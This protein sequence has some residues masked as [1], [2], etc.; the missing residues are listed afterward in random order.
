MKM[1]KQICVELSMASKLQEFLDSEKIDIKIA[2]DPPGDIEIVKVD[3]RRESGSS[4]IYSGGWISCEM[5]RNLAQKM[6][7]S[8]GQM[9]KLLNYLD[10]KIRHCSLGCFK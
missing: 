8:I 6:E 1:K 10:V 2:A 5:S 4:T 3:D 7:I 9:G